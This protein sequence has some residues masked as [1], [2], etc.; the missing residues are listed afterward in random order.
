MVRKTWFVS[1]INVKQALI[2]E[3]FKKNWMSVKRGIVMEKRWDENE[4]RLGGLPKDSP[5]IGTWQFFPY[6][7]VSLSCCFLK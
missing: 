1:G 4:K 7:S 3:I 6:S 2:E 5:Y